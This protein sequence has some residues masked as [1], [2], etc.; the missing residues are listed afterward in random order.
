MIA[1]HLTYL[2]HLNQIIIKQ[3]GG[4]FFMTAKDTLIIDEQGILILIDNLIKNGMLDKEKVEDLINE[5][6]Q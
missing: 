2:P 6:K 3:R 5:T 1:L 4:R